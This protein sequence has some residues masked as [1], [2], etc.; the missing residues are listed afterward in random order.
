M[1]TAI[2]L[3]TAGKN[4][5][6]ISK[7]REACRREAISLGAKTILEFSDEGVSGITLDRPSL[8]KLREKIRKGQIETVIVRNPDRLSRELSHMVLLVEEIEK[9]GVRLVFAEKQLE[10]NDFRGIINLFKT[11]KK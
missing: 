7:Q 4:Q 5:A 8:Q 9:A 11:E 10:I 3:R 1:H 2:Y 6:Q